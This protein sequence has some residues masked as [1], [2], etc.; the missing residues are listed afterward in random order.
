[1]ILLR[2][3]AYAVLVAFLSITVVSCPV[4]GM[5]GGYVVEPLPPGADLGT[6]AETRLVPPSEYTLEDKAR[7]FLFSNAP[8]L[9]W[10]LPLLF[11]L[12]LCLYLGYRKI[13]KNN[14]LDTPPRSVIYHYIKESPGADF[15]EISR[16]TGVKENSLR[17]HLAVL[18]LTNKV[19][20]LETSRNTRYY[21]NS[22]S[23]PPM[24]QNVLKHLKNQQTR[25]LLGLVKENP[26]LS[27]LQLQMALGLSGSGVNW[28]VQRLSEDGILA[29]RKEGRNSRYE[30]NRDAVPFLEKHLTGDDILPD[31]GHGD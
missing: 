6:P 14:V 9:L 31:R 13:K 24:E 16:E 21:E 5:T 11:I 2:G 4:A 30:L 15:T 23:Y 29:V 12:K 10:L 7:I 25:V 1:M 17:Y 20:L 26:G 19:A 3:V 22:V 18:R 28:H 8:F 27:R